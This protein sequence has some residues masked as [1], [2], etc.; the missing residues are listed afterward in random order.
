M[1]EEAVEQVDQPQGTLLETPAEVAQGGSGNDFLNMIPEDL[2]EHPSLSPIKDVGNLA[3]SYINAQQLIGADKLPAPKNP[4]EEQLSAIYNY[5]GKPESADAY[6]F[7][8]DGNIITEEVATSYKDV[9]H[10]LNLTP[11]QASGILDYYK[12]LTDSSQQQAGQQ[13]ELQREEVENNLKKEWG[14]A[15]DQKIAGA[16]EVINQFGSP[17]MLE[18]Q[19]ADGTKLGNHPEFIKAFANIADFRQSVTSEDT[20]TNATSSRAMT[21]KEA[22]AEID[23]I[24]SSSEYTDRKNVVARTRAIERV[25]ELYGMI[26][27]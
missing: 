2:R 22:Q 7:A 14:Q 19:L 13:M 21:P 17:E 10:K 9:A 20:I 11:Q 15:Y 25:Q 12:G 16:G 1:S 6:E 18:W 5:L 3:K 23:S 8:V 26:Y 27:G 24:M 4:S